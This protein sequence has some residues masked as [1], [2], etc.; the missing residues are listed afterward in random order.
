M[1]GITTSEN[2]AS[3]R[4]GIR[5]ISES[6]SSALAR[7]DR[8]VPEILQDLRAKRPTSRLSSTTRTR[9]PPGRRR[10]GPSCAVGLGRSG[11]LDLRQVEGEGRAAAEG[12]RTSTSPPGLLGEADDLGQAEAGPLADLLGG[13]ERLEDPPERV[14]RDARAGV[15]DSDTA[16]KGP[17][18]PGVPADRRQGRRP[19]HAQDQ[20]A[21]RRPSRRGR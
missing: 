19:S 3:N 6:A 7:P 15:D 20:R 1:P 4:S 8:L 5:S 11:G 21:L 10:R 14:G 2:T 13:E 12:A 17:A 16:A 18:R 9:S